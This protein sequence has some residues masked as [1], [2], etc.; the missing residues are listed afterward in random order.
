MLLTAI[1]SCSSLDCVDNIIIM[2]ISIASAAS[3]RVHHHVH[4]LYFSVQEETNEQLVASLAF[5]LL[6]CTDFFTLCIPKS[7]SLSLSLSLKQFYSTSIVASGQKMQQQ[8]RLSRLPCIQHIKSSFLCTF[9]LGHYQN[10]VTCR[11]KL[12]N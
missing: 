10:L 3:K 5:F 7:L 9:S 2:L 8:S 6:L 1:H 12:F 11:C 4:S